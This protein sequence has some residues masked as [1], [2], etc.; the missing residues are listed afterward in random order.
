MRSSEN[1][2]KQR[3]KH[4]Q[5]IVYN[6]QTGGDSDY[7]LIWSVGGSISKGKGLYQ[8]I[9]ISMTPFTPRRFTTLREL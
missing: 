7:L 3:R 2:E 6:R 8:A 4:H 1:K 9:T 5:S